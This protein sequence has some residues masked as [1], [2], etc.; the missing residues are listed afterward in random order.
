MFEKLF[1]KAEERRPPPPGISA[2]V[3]IG[4]LAVLVV[5]GVGVGYL[6]TQKRADQVSSETEKEVAQPT[7][8]EIENL[9][10]VVISDDKKR[11][12]YREGENAPWHTLLEAKDIS[13][14]IPGALQLGIQYA[15]QFGGLSVTPDKNKIIV[16]VC[17][18]CTNDLQYNWQFIFDINSKT[19]ERI[20]EGDGVLGFSPD[21][22]II[23]TTTTGPAAGHVVYY[24]VVNFQSRETIGTFKASE[25]QGELGK[26]IAELLKLQD[27]EKPLEFISF[28]VEGFTTDSQR[29]VVST[30]ANPFFKYQWKVTTNFAGEDLRLSSKSGAMALPQLDAPTLK[31]FKSYLDQREAQKDY[32][33]NEN[34][35]VVDLDLG[36]R[37]YIKNLYRSVS[38][39]GPWELA[40]TYGNPVLV[41]PFV[42]IQ[43]DFLDTLLPARARKVFYK[44]KAVNIFG[45][46]GP[47]S[48]ILEV[49]ISESD[50]MTATTFICNRKV[51]DPQE[52]VTAED[53][54]PI[55]VAVSGSPAIA[56]E[57]INALIKFNLNNVPDWYYWINIFDA[58]PDNSVKLNSLTIE[59]RMAKV[60]F[61]SDFEFSVAEAHRCLAGQITL[62][63]DQFPTISSV[64]I[65]W[66]GRKV[67][68]S[69]T[70]G[71]NLFQRFNN[72]FRI[73]KL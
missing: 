71:G 59:N 61:A 13:T 19:V 64:E 39:S 55:R 43:M 27:I 31:F 2:I 70:V 62:T 68:E 37:S 44:T 9:K 30:P 51:L 63:L 16:N 34:N 40:G 72:K 73:E 24:N 35:S 21:A 48:N 45:E 4:I 67:F 29:L 20:I 49:I 38:Q 47:D 26:R 11:L 33:K 32:F 41:G 10:D 5:V 42:Q 1:K 69:D 7:L 54:I 22:R 28:V 65:Y 36:P 6:G 17:S 50:V 3:V 66:N 58:F 60:R 8:Y 56:T 15:Q 53:F 18:N 46:E 57:I 23:L 12:L 52:N 14:E 25:A